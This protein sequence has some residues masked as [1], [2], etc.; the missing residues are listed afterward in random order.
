MPDLSLQERLAGTLGLLPT[1]PLVIADG[2][3][4]RPLVHAANAPAQRSGIEAGQP[5][6]A[7]RA[8]AAE[9]V[10]LSREPGKEQALLHRLAAWLTQFSPMTCLE[11]DGVVLE[12]STT[13]KLFGGLSALLRQIRDGLQG[14][15][16]LVQPGVAPN[17]TAAWLFARAARPA[18]GVRGC[19]A[20]QALPARLAAL[21]LVLFSWSFAAHEALSLLGLRC[22]GDL[23]AQPRAGLRKRFGEAIADDLDRALGLLP[24]AREP[25]VPPERFSAE[26]DLVFETADAARLTR[27]AR[28]LLDEM[29]GALRARCRAVDAIVLD[30]THDHRREAASVT[31]LDVGVRTPVRA[32]AAWEKLVRERLAARPLTATVCAM[33]L[34]AG[35][36][37]PWVG[38]SESW[39]PTPGQE[40]EKW[41]A[42]VDRIASRLG[43]DRVFAIEARN[44]HR[45]EAA[46][47]TRG[48][49]PASAARSKPGLPMT[50]RPRPLRLLAEPLSLVS[51]GNA[52]QHHGA[53]ALIAG[54]ERI[55]TGWWDG[56]PVARD[57]FIAVNPLDEVCWIYRDYRF[58]KRWFLQG[59]F[60]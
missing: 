39:L 15:G 27:F 19:R 3:A 5:V 45:P 28:R 51:L 11:T 31:R 42:L 25:Y 49:E 41:Q 7:A 60:S 37:R 12:V 33:A 48:T 38:E 30:L 29:E 24:D 23:A 17:P 13:L 8:R 14:L 58:G 50:A 1:V 52:P 36:P 35:T 2:P 44:D 56:R 53:L 46:W 40:R 16:F 34:H 59:Y 32:A 54:P 10:V 57:Y 20:S 18:T 43:Q 55:E 22:I 4:N 26:I 9:L 6:A 21:P 47:A